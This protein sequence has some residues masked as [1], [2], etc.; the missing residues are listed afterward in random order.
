MFILL[1]LFAFAERV[2]GEQE[3][4]ASD[5]LQIT[6]RANRA[7]GQDVLH[8]AVTQARERWYF[9]MYARY[10]IASNDRETIYL[11]LKGLCRQWRFFYWRNH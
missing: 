10:V 5:W 7:T 3:V 2:S 6:T 9:W 1:M 8:H 11:G 4:R